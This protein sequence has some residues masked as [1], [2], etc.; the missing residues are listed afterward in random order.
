MLPLCLD[1]HQNSRGNFLNSSSPDQLH[2]NLWGGARLSI[3]TAPQ[4][5][6]PAAGSENQAIFRPTLAV[7]AQAT[8]NGPRCCHGADLSP[9]LSL[10]E[11]KRGQM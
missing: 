8:S 7:T 6:Q 4:G 1:V 9:Q 11:R 2:Q 3:A 5:L 10:S